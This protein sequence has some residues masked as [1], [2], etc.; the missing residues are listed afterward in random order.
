M[1]KSLRGYLFVVDIY[2]KR[3][4]LSSLMHKEYTRMYAIM[5]IH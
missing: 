3:I 1:I 4:T 5:F 2:E